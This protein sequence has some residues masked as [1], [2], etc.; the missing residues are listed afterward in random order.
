[1]LCDG[2]SPLAHI[3]PMLESL[4]VKPELSL[5]ESVE[6][7]VLGLINKKVE[8]KEKTPL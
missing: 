4:K 7:A 3:T 8:E 5:F 2:K 1:M 6:K